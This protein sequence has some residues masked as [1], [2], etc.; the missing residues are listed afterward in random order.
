MQET[1]ALELERAIGYNIF[2]ILQKKNMTVAELAGLIGC[3]EMHM[4]AIVTGSIHIG[5]EE[6]EKIAETLGVDKHKLLDMPDA[7]QMKDYNIHYM[8]MVTNQQA[9]N[10][11][12]DKVDIYVR[13]LNMQ[14][15]V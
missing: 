11:I 13:L 9:M 8:G 12:L 2:Q 4:Q 14:T 10:K 15:D 1:Y 6:I 5:E 7:E 3:P